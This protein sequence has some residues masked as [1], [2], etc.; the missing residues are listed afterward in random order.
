MLLKFELRFCV[1]VRLQKN[2]FLTILTR[3]GHCE[4]RCRAFSR[5][6]SLTLDFVFGGRLKTKGAWPLP[7]VV[8]VGQV[9]LPGL[10]PPKLL[11]TRPL[12]ELLYANQGI[13]YCYPNNRATDLV[14]TMFIMTS[15]AVVVQIN[16]I[17]FIR[18]LKADYVP[19]TPFHVMIAR[20]A[21]Y[22]WLSKA[23]NAPGPS[24]N[25]VRKGDDHT[26]KTGDDD[27]LL[28]SLMIMISFVIFSKHRGPFL[29]ILYSKIAFFFFF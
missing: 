14:V 7:R 6:S 26:D 17:D 4:K 19:Q 25:Q 2:V 3:Y 16:L 27:W 11:C 29:S 12:L 8:G 10:Q 9:G 28:T 13:F 23:G 24:G 5:C 22:Q 18:R 1:L 15:S 21:I 20:R